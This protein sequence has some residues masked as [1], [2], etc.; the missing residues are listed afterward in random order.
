MLKR[1]S[2]YRLILVR[3]GRLE[4]LIKNVA[5]DQSENKDETDFVEDLESEAKKA[6]TKEETQ[7]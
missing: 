4:H 6:E 3:T 7:K 5:S 1:L 2:S